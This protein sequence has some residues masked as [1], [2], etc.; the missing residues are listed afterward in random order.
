MDQFSRAM[1]LLPIHIQMA[2]TPAQAEGDLTHRPL[3]PDPRP[4]LPTAPS[5]KAMLT[6]N[7]FLPWRP[8]H[9]PRLL[10]GRVGGG[11]AEPLRWGP[12]QSPWCPG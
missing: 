11:G 8:P 12:P 5:Q 10:R 1:K 2:F 4:P 9:H 3:T 6:G 7:V